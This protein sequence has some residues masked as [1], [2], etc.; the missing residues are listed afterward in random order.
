MASLVSSLFLF[1]LLRFFQVDILFR[2]LGSFNELRVL[3]LDQSNEVHAENHLLLS[4]RVLKE[5][6]DRQTLRW[7]IFEMSA[8]NVENARHKL[9]VVLGVEDIAL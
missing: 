2:A 5:V 1:N 7:R 6:V 8:Q 9:L 4:K 3:R